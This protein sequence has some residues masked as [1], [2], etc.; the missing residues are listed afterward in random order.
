[1]WKK[2]TSLVMALVIVL[3]AMLGIAGTAV[4]QAE[5]PYTVYFAYHAPKEG[6]QKELNAVMNELTMKELGMKV[7]LI[8]VGWDTY[9]QKY[10]AMLAAQ[11][12]L[13]ISFVFAFS[14]AS[15]L[16]AGYIVD[17]ANYTQYTQDIFKVLGDD[18]KVGYIGNM[19]VGFPVMNTRAAPSAIFVRK[20][21]FDALGYKE[22]DFNV[23]TDDYASFDKVTEML[24]KIKAAYPDMIPFDGHRIFA[25]NSF[26]W[27][28]AL[29][30]GFGVLENYGQTTKVT[31]W[32]ES[33][34]M[35]AFCKLARDWFEKGYTSKDIAVTQ[36]LGQAKMKAGKCAAFFASYTANALT[37]VKSQT[38]YDC[39]MIPI[40]AKM[41]STTSVNAVLNC[42]M[43]QSRDKVKAFQFLNWAYTSKEF[44]DLLNWGVP[45]KDWI[46]NADGQ[47]DYPE[48]VNAQNVNYHSDFGFIYP[49]QFLMT[50]WAGS[51]ANVWD[52]YKQ[53]DEGCLVSKAFGF[54]FDSTNV[55][56]EVTQC[57]A[58]L[59]KYQADVFFGAVDPVEGLA[60][61]NKDLYAAG[62]QTII[63][64]KQKQLDAWLAN[65]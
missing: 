34:Q 17:A 36:E 40:S 26:T 54:N 62:L 21:I 59:T 45:G 20:D 33:A 51:P 56:N 32:Y 30:D 61:L 8:P 60:N 31:N 46:V 50:P 53:F 23:T 10:S 19:L 43:Q 42:V 52:T 16:D 3:T 11:Q 1:M 57:S 49:N 15:F 39:V 25:E 5:E 27:V 22:S 13:D 9:N 28:D 65:H 14:F 37:G 2:G 7:E 4:A 64:E 35:T 6:N 63:D 44:N 58:V 48:G 12:P 24:G 29:S 41:K 47:A 55:V 38:G 18:A